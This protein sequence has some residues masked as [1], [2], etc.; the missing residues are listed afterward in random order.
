MA[1]RDEE[2]WRQCISDELGRRDDA[3]KPDEGWPWPWDDSQTTDY[4]YAF[5]GGKV[6][7][8]CFG[9]AWFEIDRSSERYGEP[10]SDLE[11]G[12]VVFPDMSE[13]KNVRYD[14]ASG[15]IFLTRRSVGGGGDDAR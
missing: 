2:Q 8:S 9:H 5:D 14:N 6:W 3:T 10:D 4:A 7:G 12:K 13:R 1:D 11:D 15:A